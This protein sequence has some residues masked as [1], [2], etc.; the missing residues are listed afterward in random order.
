M[1]PAR[2]VDDHGRVLD[3]PTPPRRVVSLVPSDTLNVAAL[4]CAGAL[5]G[6]TDYCELPEDVARRVPSVGGTK[7]PRVDDVVALAPDLVIAN[8]EE[9]TRS[10]L[11]T[12]AQRGVRVYVAFPK[13]VAH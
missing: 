10:D 3:F 6:R 8:Q 4:G 1:T 12:L 9:N 7:N 13:R 11:E 2:I 5:V